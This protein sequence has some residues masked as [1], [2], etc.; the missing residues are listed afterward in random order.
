MSTLV[1]SAVLCVLVLSLLLV[2]TYR[3]WVARKRGM[4]WAPRRK[5][6]VTI[7]YAITLIQVGHGMLVGRGAGRGPWRSG[8]PAPAVDAWR[9]GGAWD[10][11]PVRGTALPMQCTS[12]VRLFWQLLAGFHALDVLR[13][14]LPPS[15]HRS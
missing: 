14:P 2:L 5:R 6:L 10:P 7:T 8:A 1:I 13:I 4:R 3:I 11:A 12:R 9:G 15:T